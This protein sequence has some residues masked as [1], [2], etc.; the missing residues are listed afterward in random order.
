MALLGPGIEAQVRALLSRLDDPVVLHYFPVD[1]HPSS[2]SMQRLLDELAWV[3][4]KLRVFHHAGPILPVAPEMADDREG[5][6]TVVSTSDAAAS[7][8]FLGFPGGHEFAVLLQSLVAVST[9]RDP[10]LGTGT[11]QFLAGFR[12]PLHFQVFVTPT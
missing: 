7:I 3:N 12:H 8:R 9:R 1:G 10:Q 2:D 4:P 5:P 11:K 6:V